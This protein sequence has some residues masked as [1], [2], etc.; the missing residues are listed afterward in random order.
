MELE[1]FHKLKKIYFTILFNNEL[2]PTEKRSISHIHI[3]FEHDHSSC[4]V[5]DYNVF[6]GWDETGWDGLK[7]DGTGRDAKV[8]P[9]DSSTLQQ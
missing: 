9:F 6:T 7:R 2:R 4:L 3:V 5:F 8:V 1:Y